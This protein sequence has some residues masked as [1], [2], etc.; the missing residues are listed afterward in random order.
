MMNARP[1]WGP[2][3]DPPMSQPQAY[4]PPPPGH[5]FAPPIG[6]QRP[7]LPHA[8]PRPN[9]EMPSKMPGPPQQYSAAAYGGEQ[10]DELCTR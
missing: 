9:M 8:P 1:P 6:Q 5:H 3:A 7:S 10:N 4:L 2:P